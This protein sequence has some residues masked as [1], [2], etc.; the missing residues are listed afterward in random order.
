MVEFEGKC[1]RDMDAFWI[2]GSVGFLILR[3]IQA[4]N[5]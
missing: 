2:Y 5:I 3:V 1:E 4:G